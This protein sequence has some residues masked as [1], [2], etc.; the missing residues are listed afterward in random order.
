MVKEIIKDVEVLSKV[1]EPFNFRTDK[2]IIQDL[3]DTAKFH[4][5]RCVGLA[6][7]QIGELKRVVVVKAGDTY[8]SFINPKIIKRDNKKYTT[9]EAC[10]SLEGE[11]EVIRHNEITIL[12]EVKSGKYVKQTFRGY[13]AQIIQHEIDHLNGILI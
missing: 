7:V 5:D 6:A 13:A 8:I 4:E 3:I 1:S 10:M 2:H 12:H 11:R 9:K